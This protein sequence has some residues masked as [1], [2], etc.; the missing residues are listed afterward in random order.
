MNLDCEALMNAIVSSA[1]ATGCFENVNMH[2]PEGN[3]GT[4]TAALWLQAITPARGGSG[5]NATSVRAE[6]TLRI[7][8]N[9]IAAPK[10]EI[11]PQLASTT[12]AVLTALSGGF[13]IG[14][15]VREVDLLGEFG[16]PLGAQAGYLNLS[17]ALYRIMDLTIPVV[18]DDVFDQ[19]P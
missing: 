18:V 4:Y 5:L 1:L 2:E 15:T 7:Y 13:S 16:K 14:D 6:F 8:S 10:D 3:V 11:D 9:M 19:T 12:A 17:T